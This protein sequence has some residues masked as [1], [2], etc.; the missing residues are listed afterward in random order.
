M[1]VLKNFISDFIIN[2][3]CPLGFVKVNAGKPIN[4]NYYDSK[5]LESAVRDFIISNIQNSNLHCGEI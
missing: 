1:E 4:Y 2:S 5:E 3:V